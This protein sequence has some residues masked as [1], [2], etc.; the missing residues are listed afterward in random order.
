M[1]RIEE[2]HHL[3]VACRYWK[4][5]YV[6]TGARSSESP[7]VLRDGRSQPSLYSA[8]DA[9]DIPHHSCTFYTPSSRDASPPGSSCAGVALRIVWWKQ[10]R[11][12][13]AGLIA[14]GVPVVF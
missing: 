3:F 2:T 14:I 5:S 10:R 12:I 9:G 13:V 8:N 1:T 11:Q 7:F 4:A 6:G